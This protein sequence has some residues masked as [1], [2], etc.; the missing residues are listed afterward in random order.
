M[1]AD[2]IKD[3]IKSGKG[4]TKNSPTPKPTLEKEYIDRYKQKKD[5]KV[6]KSSLLS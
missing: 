3:M 1:G 6:N 2:N 4:G 5:G